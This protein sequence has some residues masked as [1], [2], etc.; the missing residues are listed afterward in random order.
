MDS[1]KIKILTVNTHKGF[2]ALNRRFILHELRDAV[3]ILSADLVFLQEVLGEH[4][5]L[6]ERH[7]TLWPIEPHYEFLA[8]TIWHSYAYGRNAVYPEGHHGN[9]LLSKYP[10]ERWQ[11]LD[12]SLSGMERRGLLHSEIDVGEGKKPLHAV[13]VHLSLRESHRQ[14][15]LKLLC[16]YVNDLPADEPLVVAGDFNDWGQR[17]QAVLW[18]NAGLQEVFTQVYGK[19]ARTFPAAL[20]FLRLDRIYVR[21]AISHLPVVLPNSPWSHLSDHKP[22]LAEIEF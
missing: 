21:S 16:D 12:I 1:T 11:N 4:Q 22:L 9:A 6:S 18:D 13:C 10:I 15:Q 8:D 20:P 3:R 17:A 2:T 19:P 5:A 7:S 14:K